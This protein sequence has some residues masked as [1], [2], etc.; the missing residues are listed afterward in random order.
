MAVVNIGARIKSPS[1]DEGNTNFSD[2]LNQPES[3]VSPAVSES[4]SDTVGS[5][6][7]ASDRSVAA[8]ASIPK[9]C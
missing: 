9:C 4:I 1:F 7:G 3:L 6:A 5:V 8:K 2:G